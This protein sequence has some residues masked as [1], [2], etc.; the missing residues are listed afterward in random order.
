M[1]RIRLVENFREFMDLASI[2][3]G[4]DGWSI[5]GSNPTTP[6]LIKSTSNKYVGH[7]SCQNC[8]HH[9]DIKKSDDSPYFCHDCGYDNKKKEFDLDKLKKWLNKHHRKENTD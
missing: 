8:L 3:Q 7:T 4:P 2:N 9:W 1:S 5:Y 6:K